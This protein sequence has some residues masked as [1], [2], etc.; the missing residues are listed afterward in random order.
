LR[1]RRDKARFAPVAPGLGD[2]GWRVA[3]APGL[4]VRTR[5]WLRAGGSLTH[6]LA[7]LG[8]VDVRIVR[9]AW[10]APLRDEQRCCRGRSASRRVWTREVLLCVAGEPYVFAHSVT[11]ADA[12]RHVWRA[13]RSLGRR[14]L[15]DMLFGDPGVTRTRRVSRRL[16]PRHAL[17]RRTRRHADLPHGAPVARRSV[18]VRGGVPLV[19]TE[20]LLPALRRRIEAVPP[21]CAAS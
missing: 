12:A 3:A 13:M 11:P 10:A 19:V 4:S 15:A 21:S 14:P 6:R 17:A 8:P 18:F 7:M 9:E 5:D 1:R 16:P 2:G 20:C